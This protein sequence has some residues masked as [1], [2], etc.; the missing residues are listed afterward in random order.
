MKEQ[1]EK[2]IVKTF[3]GRQVLITG[4]AGYIAASLVQLLKNVECHII[5]LDRP[6]VV[7]PP[8]D[9]KAQIDNIHSDIR[10]RGIWEKVLNKT[11]F[12]FHLAAQTS[13]Y[14][15]NEDPFADIGINVLPLLDMLET[16]RKKKVKPIVLFSSTVTVIGIPKKLPVNESHTGQPLT[17]YDLHKLAAENYLSYYISQDY[18]RGAILRLS[19]VYGPGPKSSSADRGILNLMIRKALAGET[20]TVYNTGDCLRD[21]IYIEDIARAFL[22]AAINVK[23]VNGRYFVIGSGQGHT[24]AEAINLVGDRAAIK[25]GRR[26]DVIHV[27]PEFPQSPVETRNFVADSRQFSNATGWKAKVFLVEGID[28]TIESY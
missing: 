18:V 13:T 23:R 5:R 21:Y 1:F 12:I 7:P 9:G 25:T 3:A 8:I 6:D 27:E 2:N 28:R 17:V 26:V 14:A 24:I 10:D 16:C 15:A 4:G 11:D 19:N 22:M 20:L